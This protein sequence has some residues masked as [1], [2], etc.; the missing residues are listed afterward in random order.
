MVHKTVATAALLL[1]AVSP[2]GAMT[3]VDLVGKVNA[4]TNGTNA[5]SILLPKGKYEVRFVEG[6]FTAHNRFN[7]SVS[8]CN[9]FGTNCT[10][11][12]ETNARFY[13]GA[14]DLDTTNDFKVGNFTYH[15]TRELAFAASSA[16]STQ[17]LVPA[18]GS[19]VSFYIFDPKISDNVEGVSLGIAAIPEART[20][21]MLIVGFGLV[22][23]AM[24]RRRGAVAAA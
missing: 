10:R 6:Q 15:A 2:A 11:G 1:A 23:A 3:I 5:V 21:A 4:S 8:G 13:L 14:N 19:Q 17:F 18:G 7:G 24:R 16:F 22:G 20:W 9:A 12:W